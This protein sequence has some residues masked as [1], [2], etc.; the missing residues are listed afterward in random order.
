[1]KL[2]EIIN[3]E[4]DFRIVCRMNDTIKKVSAD[5]SPRNAVRIKVNDK[6]V[7]EFK[8]LSD[9][10]REY[11]KKVL[12]NLDSKKVFGKKKGD[13]CLKL[14]ELEIAGYEEL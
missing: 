4:E 7:L 14:L 2:R 5:I 1:M 11:L 3:K 10:K 12:D 13:V 8:E 9:G 6:E